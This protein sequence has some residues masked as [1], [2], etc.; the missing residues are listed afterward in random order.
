MTVT[1]ND[2]VLLLDEGTPVI[3]LLRNQK[4]PLT[5]I[6]VAVNQSVL[7]KNEWEGF[8]LNDNDNITLIKATQGG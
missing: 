2:A 7:K 1:V 8:I 5:G 4:I 6:A 3:N